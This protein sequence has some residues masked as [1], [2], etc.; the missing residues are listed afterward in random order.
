VTDQQ[1][2]DLSV[3]AD[4]LED[5]YVGSW[6]GTPAERDERVRHARR[7]VGLRLAA[8]TY[9]DID[10]RRF[11][12][13]SD[14]DHPRVITDEADWHEP[15]WRCPGFDAV[16][17]GVELQMAGGRLFSVSWDP[18]G[19]REGIGLREMSASAAGLLG[20]NVA[21]WEVGRR[22]AWEHLIGA[23][24]TD[25]VPHYLPWTGRP[26][27]FWCPRITIR[28]GA[29]NVELLLG[30]EGPD[31]TLAPSADTVAVVFAPDELPAW[32]EPPL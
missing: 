2:P 15:V 8:V 11:E 16:D 24:I 32:V 6:V 18:P 20:D 17:Y 10:Y 25:V 23:E 5:D 19:D 13:A 12:V 4:A 29:T 31:G 21:I 7:L 9:F 1:L 27:G 26:A 22:G 28:F 14:G 30:G 3:P